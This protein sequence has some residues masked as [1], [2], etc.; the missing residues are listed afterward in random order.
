MPLSPPGFWTPAGKYLQIIVLKSQSKRGAGKWFQKVTYW[1]QARL[2]QFPYQCIE[3][4]TRV[5]GSD[6]IYIHPSSCGWSICS[7]HTL[8]PP[9]L[10]D[11]YLDD[12]Y[13][14]KIIWDSQLHSEHSIFD[15]FNTFYIFHTSFHSERLQYLR[16]RLRSNVCCLKHWILERVQLNGI[17]HLWAV[18]MRS[19]HN[20]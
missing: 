13:Y 20:R 4:T 11:A 12:I 5:Q 10:I 3:W 14:E 2:H 17:G 1:H 7:Y 8:V 9:P 15:S 16:K 6:V 18:R 19:L